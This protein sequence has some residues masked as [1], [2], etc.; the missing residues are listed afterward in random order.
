MLNLYRRHTA[1]CKYS[2]ADRPSEYL[3]C[4]CPI[5][6]YGLIE[7]KEVRRAVKLRD[8]A[9][10]TKQVEEWERSGELKTGKTLGTAIIDY[11][12]D[13]K[14]RNVQD[15]T[16]AGYA[17]TLGR[18]RSFIGEKKLLESIT[19]E[20][21]SEFRANRRYTPLKAGATERRVLP[22]TTI[23]ETQTIRG[24]FNFC[25]D[26]LWMTANPAKKLK[27]PKGH[28]SPTMPFEPEEVDAILE[29]CDRLPDGNPNTRDVNR[30]KARARIL[31]LLHTGFRLSDMV[32]LKRADVD[33]KSGRIRIVSQKTNTKQYVKLSKEPLD[34]LCALPHDGPRFFWN[35][36][37]R[38]RSAIGTAR[39]SISRVLKMAGVKG[40]P[41]RFR[42]TFSVELLK[43]GTDL[44]TVQL[45]LGHSSI[46]MTEDH[47]AP[48]VKSFQDILDR[49]TAKLSFGKRTQKRTID[50]GGKKH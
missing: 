48:W 45:L 43:R 8:W 36:E 31:I 44:R 49:E 2:K 38:L 7:G 20:Q 47:Y 26:R 16:I 40:H 24:F 11:L 19:L 50:R 41:H 37:S 6:A 10:A 30:L 13:C 1:T 22:K 32:K 29:A 33:M 39:L 28:T 3:K 5:W 15:S 42:D 34:A 12:A 23:K 25:L 9:R 27:Q 4:P 18:L 35:G 14:A 46:K 21:L 17:M